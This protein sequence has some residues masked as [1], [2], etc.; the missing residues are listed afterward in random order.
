MLEAKGPL[1]LLEALALVAQRGAAFDA[2]FAGAWRG[3]LTPAAFAAQVHAGGLD[4]RVRHCGPVRG[5]A[6]HALFV[7]ADI[8]VLPTHYE[9]EALPVVV[10][11]AMMH[12]LPV[13]TTRVGALPDLVTDGE[14]GD[15][16]APRDAAGLADALARL[17]H[18]PERRRRYGAAGRARYEAELTDARFEQ[19]LLACL[20]GALRP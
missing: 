20:S 15:L 8:F 9:H 11:E 6:K 10:I 13:V 3:A 16:V 18:E 7:D 17:M 19:R 4:D 5:S 2:V 14:T 12:G 1:L